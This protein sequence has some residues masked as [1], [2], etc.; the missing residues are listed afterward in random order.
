MCQKVSRMGD[1]AAK[2][3]NAF[4]KSHAKWGGKA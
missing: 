4:A 1:V 3:A 2:A